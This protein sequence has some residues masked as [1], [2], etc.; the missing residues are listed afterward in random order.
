MG[1]YL[2]VSSTRCLLSLSVVQNSSTFVGLAEVCRRGIALSGC[3]GTQ[4][5]GVAR[6]SKRMAKQLDWENEDL[7]QMLS[8]AGSNIVAKKK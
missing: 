8:L 4:A 6:G 5:A 3:R 1:A 7:L 2:L